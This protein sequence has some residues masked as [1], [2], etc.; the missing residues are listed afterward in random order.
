MLSSRGRPHLTFGIALYER[1]SVWLVVLGG[2]QKPLWTSLIRKDKGALAAHVPP[3][4]G[5]DVGA[6]VGGD[7]GGSS[8]GWRE[9]LLLQTILTPLIPFSYLLSFPMLPH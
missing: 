9:P 3:E 1:L 5:V 4:P 7:Q 6:A 2:R 8:A